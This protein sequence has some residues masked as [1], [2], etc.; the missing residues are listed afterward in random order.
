MTE[1]LIECGYCEEEH[2]LFRATLPSHVSESKWRQT[3]KLSA[4]TFQRIVC[5]HCFSAYTIEDD[6][7]PLESGG[8]VRSK[9]V[10]APV[11]NGISA[12]SGPRNG[13]NIVGIY[14]HGLD[15]GESLVVK[16]A[17]QPSLKIDERTST[18]ARVVVPTATYT[19]NVASYAVQ[20][21][22]NT[23]V[24]GGFQ[25][26]ETIS[27]ANGFTGTVQKVDSP[28]IMVS[29]AG[30]SGSLDALV[31]VTISG[32]S[33]GTHATVV[34]AMNVEFLV[35]EP[36]EG[37][38]SKARGTVVSKFP[39]QIAAPSAGFAP[40]ELVQGQM[41][42]ALCK[43]KTSPAYSGQVSVTV[44]NDYGQRPT[45]SVLVGAYTFA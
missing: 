4:S 3:W 44:E 2:V 17:G 24:G 1:L 15:I 26:G 31:G 42:K 33:S 7:V 13:G 37:L 11:I 35:G 14:G 40:Q 10:S 45:G 8:F 23:F 30:A 6:G 21:E 16:F 38:S 41:S 27:S 28:K 29:L 32:G 34:G 5:S 20:I 9:D 22:Y 25:A 12:V 36:V 43:L 18:T 39:L 19:L